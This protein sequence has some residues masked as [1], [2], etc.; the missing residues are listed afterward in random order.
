MSCCSCNTSP[1]SCNSG[2]DATRESVS[3]AL[4]NFIVEFF[5][6]ISKVC[7]NGAVVWALPCD[8]KGTPV[9][10]YPRIPNEGLACYFVRVFNTVIT[11]ILS[12][13]VIQSGRESIHDGLD[14]ATVVFPAPFTSAPTVRVSVARP[15]GAPLI[16]ANINSDSIT[17][18][19]FTADLSAL[20]PDA[21]YILM[22]E[23]T[24]V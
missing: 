16:F 9:P 17:A 22:W 7:V 15:A 19:G 13:G 4:N 2:C 20:A 14:T 5:G 3:S 21:N 12:F 1:C 11:L 24:A 8:L 6:V 23:A 10:G 18:T